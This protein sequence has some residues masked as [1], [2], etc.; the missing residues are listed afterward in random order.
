MEPSENGRRIAR[1]RLGDRVVGSLKELDPEKFDVV[2]LWHVLEHVPTP[3]EMLRQIHLH[4][5]PGGVFCA[6]VPNF[7]SLQARLGK[8]HWSHLDV[9]RHYFHYT[10][11]TLKYVLELAGYTTLQIDHFSIEF[12]PIG[13]LQ[14]ALNL[15][16]CEPGLIYALVKRNISWR[17]AKSKV[18]FLYSVMMA[19]VGIPL[20]ILPAILFAYLESLIGKGGSILVYATPVELER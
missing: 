6:A 15:L 17:T 1:E 16:G 18:R 13:V 14:T 10:P 4:M 3:V 11:D 19:I 12:N 2:V 20:L 8:S 9:P 7:A 5:T